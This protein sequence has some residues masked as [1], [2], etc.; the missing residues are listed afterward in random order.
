MS[1]NITELRQINNNRYDYSKIS[2]DLPLPNLVEIQTKSY[3]EFLE[4]GLNEV[5]QESFP[6]ENYVGTLTIEYLSIRLGEPKHSYLECKEKDL[7]YN[8]PMYITVRLIHKE[9]GE[10]QESEVFMGDLPL[11]TSSGTFI[12]NGAERVIV[13]QLVRS[14]GAYLSKE[15]KAGK[16]L[17]EADLIPGRGTW[18]QFESDAKDLLSVRIDRQ[19]KIHATTL[20]RALGLETSEDIEK[21]FGENAALKNTLEKEESKIKTSKAALVDIFRK[22]KPGEPVTEEGTVNF[23]VQRFFDEKR[24]DLGRAGRYKFIKKLGI[25]NR[26][27]GRI[28]AENLVSA[29]G[30]IR[31]KKGYQLTNEDVEALRNEE[32]FEQGAHLKEV[33][34]NKNLNDNGRVNIVKVYNND[35]DKKVS[36]IIGTDLK[37][38]STYVNI[39]D[40]IA[41][42]SYFLN[43]M[44]G[45]GDTDDIDHLG[46]RRIRCVGELIQN[47]FRVGLAKMLKTVQQKM[48][49]SDLGNVKPKALINP[50]PLV[51]SIREFFASSQLSQFMDQTNPLAELTNKR[52]LSALGPGGLTRDRASTEVR[53]VHVSHYG[54][55]C[56]IETPEGV[57][58]TTSPHTRK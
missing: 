22:M 57:L 36:V 48:S 24:Y 26:L 52:R 16:Y 32:F 58:L 3:A 7:T 35:K 49:I 29:E 47:Q 31:F 42:F 39:C 21:L 11:M 8:V 53:D 9:T 44:D 2:G 13:S 18:L 25:Y 45:F 38:T 51:A 14:P 34:I 23:L 4:K 10:I 27:P 50:R 40:I 5:F 30:E 46:N 1:R 20:L 12:V 41:V 15:F 37:N 43:V 56:P 19:R 6:I 33:K 28:L 17:Y 54:R 55:I